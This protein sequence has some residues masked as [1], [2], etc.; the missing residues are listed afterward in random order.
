MVPDPTES[1]FSG[2][3]SA[4][5][6]ERRRFRPSSFR[7]NRLPFLRGPGEADSGYLRQ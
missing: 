4:G 5:R 6:G 3:A 7:K 1:P 2:A